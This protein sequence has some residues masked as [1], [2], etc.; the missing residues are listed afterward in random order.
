MPETTGA[1]LKQAR[2]E[3]GL[4]FDQVV[5]AT[6]IRLH[7]LEALEQDDLSAIPSSAQARG[8]L[9]IYAD[10]LGLNPDQLV[11]AARLSEPQ[12]AVSP[13]DPATETTQKAAPIPEAA[14]PSL[15]SS[16][17]QR[18]TRHPDSATSQP[19]MPRAAASLDAQRPAPEP[20]PFVPARFKEELPAE[21]APMSEESASIE[22]PGTVAKA[23]ERKTSPR[24]SGVSRTVK[25]PAPKTAKSSQSAGAGKKAGEKKKIK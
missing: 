19:E 17:R 7:Y 21:P 15:L 23:P 12:P 11:A 4:T 10:F 18:F 22:E 5:K 16:L 13:S 14:R 9:R 2:E 25:K 8:F 20:E 3:R 1:R 6:R 24:R